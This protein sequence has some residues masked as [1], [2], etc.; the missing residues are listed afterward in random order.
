LEIILLLIANA[1]FFVAGIE[2]GFI[3]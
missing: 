3:F 2:T 1:L